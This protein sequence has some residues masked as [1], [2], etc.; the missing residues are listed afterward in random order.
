MNAN[1]SDEPSRGQDVPFDSH[2]DGKGSAV[3][4]DGPPVAQ[5]RI[6]VDPTVRRKR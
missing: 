4:D 2:I 1:F 3:V 5:E 6:S